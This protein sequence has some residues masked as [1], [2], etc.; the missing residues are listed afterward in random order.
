MTDL[1]SLQ[2]AFQRHI[3]RP[4]RV[5]TRTV[6][7]TPRADAGRRLGVYS[8]GYRSRLIE[9]LANDYPALRCTLG[10]ARF[11]GTMRAF[12]AAHP[13]RHANLR[14]YGGELADFL[15][16]APRCRR[17]PL[18]AELARFEWALGLAFDAADA[19]LAAAQD[20]AAVPA[21]RW[22]VMR[23]ALHPS[24]HRLDLRTNAP[25]LWLAAVRRRVLPRG[26]LRRRP[27]A[28]LIWR[29]EHAPYFRSLARDEAVALALA[30]RGADFAAIG[31]SLARSAGGGNAALRAAQ[32]LRNWLDE[33]LISAVE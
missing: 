21:H 23:L 2:C 6:L 32:L 16:R 29:K 10:E 14:W 26:V 12:I 30:A 22:P 11:D 19:P 7:A 13:S 27:R 5:M 1:A 8:D 31:R 33:G 9:A 17:R 20:A 18:L 28:W 15:S 24:V 3:D 4:T 25:A